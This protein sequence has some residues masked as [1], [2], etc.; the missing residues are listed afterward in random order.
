MQNTG[1][2]ILA[3]LV[4]CIV[5]PIAGL[6]FLLFKCRGLIKIEGYWATFWDILEGNLVIISNHPTMRDPLVYV[7]MWW[8]ACIIFPRK[9]LVWNLPGKNYFDDVLSSL[10]R[11]TWTN[12]PEWIYPI[13]HCI[14]VDRSG[15]NNK[16]VIR[17]AN[18]VVTNGHTLIIFGETRR[19]GSQ[20]RNNPEAEIIFNYNK[21]GSRQIQPFT[22]AVIKTTANKGARFIVAWKNYDNWRIDPGFGLK[23]WWKDK[24][25]VTINFGRSYYPD[26]TLKAAELL[27]DTQQR[28]L[29]IQ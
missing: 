3:W 21:D 25:Q 13:I 27:L 19:T 24:H 23:T 16:D 15:G 6:I 22:A 12:F 11:G 26:K 18:Q 10:T 1:R 29:S 8:W 5:G 4:I 17:K 28:V 9:F 20:D 7:G 14:Q 2:N